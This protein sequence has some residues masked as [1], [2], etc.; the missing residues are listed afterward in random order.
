MRLDRL[1]R[2]QVLSR[3]EAFGVA[4]EIDVCTI[5][6]HPFYDTAQQLTN[7][8]FVLLDDLL[9]LCLAHLL[10]DD[11]LGRL[12]RDPSEF[13][14]FHGLLHILAGLRLGIVIDGVLKPQLTSRL[15]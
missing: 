12:C 11:L 15:L 4:T 8:V 1:A 5:A 14:G 3:D 13:D 2:Y 7:A 9:S 6:I 10:H